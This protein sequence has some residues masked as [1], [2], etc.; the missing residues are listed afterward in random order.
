MKS[1]SVPQAK[2]DLHVAA[3]CQLHLLLRFQRPEFIAI[4]DGLLLFV[5]SSPKLCARDLLG[6]DLASRR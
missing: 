1:C 5:G 2:N 4:T 6:S 3:F